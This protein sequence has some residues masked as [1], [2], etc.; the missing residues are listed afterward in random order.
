MVLGGVA[1]RQRPGWRPHSRLRDMRSVW[2]ATDAAQSDISGTCC[3][4]AHPRDEKHE[5][6]HFG[7]YFRSNDD[8]KSATSVYIVSGWTCCLCTYQTHAGN[9]HRQNDR[10]RRE[11]EAAGRARALRQT[12]L[13]QL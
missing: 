8:D 12:S 11:E 6:S 10:P 9:K 2:A 7:S 13:G 3:N 5:E 4:A 1:M